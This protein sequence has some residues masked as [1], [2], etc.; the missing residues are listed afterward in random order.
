MSRK[1]ALITGAT[2]GIGKGIALE[3]A[4]LGLNIVAVGTRNASQAA[5]AIEEIRA[6]DVEVAYVQADVSQRE[7]RDRMVEETKKAFGRLDVL[8]NNAGVAP[9]ERVDVLD[10]S[11]ESFDWVFGINLRGPLFLTQRVAKWMVEQK[12]HE[13]DREPMIVNISSVSAYASSPGRAQYCISKAGMSMMTL[14]YADRLA[15]FGIRVYEIRPG[16]VATDMTAAAKAKYDK[17]I[18]AGFTPIARWGLPE[19]VGKAVAAIVQGALPFSTGE[20]INVDGGFH[21]RRL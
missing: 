6:N 4:R 20:V 7:G 16:V 11:E 1:S 9:K 19:D 15:E 18:D 17:L 8:V 14:L 5:G 10:M 21:M 12:Q 13:P 2:R 3:L